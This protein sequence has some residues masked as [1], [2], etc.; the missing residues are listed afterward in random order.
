MSVSNGDCPN[1]GGRGVALRLGP[2]GADSPTCAKCNGTG[3]AAG[4][5][6]DYEILCDTCRG[7]AY[8]TNPEWNNWLALPPSKRGAK[9]QEEFVCGECDGVGYRLTE[10]GMRLLSFLRRHVGVA[11]K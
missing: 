9:P 6:M 5:L 1:C 8:V 2:N 10:E 11:L 4:G 3:A 7:A